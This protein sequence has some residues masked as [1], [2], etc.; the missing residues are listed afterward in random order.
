RASTTGAS[1][2]GSSRS[3]HATA[4]APDSAIWRSGTTTPTAPYR[5]T[6][7]CSPRCAPERGSAP[8]T[9]TVPKR[10]PSP[11][12]SG[13]PSQAAS[14]RAS[15]HPG[16]GRAA[17]AHTSRSWRSTL[18]SAH[19]AT[20]TTPGQRPTTPAPGTT[21][22]RSASK[23]TGSTSHAA[24]AGGP[25]ARPARHRPGDGQGRALLRT[26]DGNGTGRASRL[27]IRTTVVAGGDDAN[28]LRDQ[29][30]AVVARGSV[31]HE[32]VTPD[33]TGRRSP[34]AGQ[35]APTSWTR[36]V[37]ADS[38]AISCRSPLRR[39]FTSITPFARP[40]P[41][42]TIVGTPISSASVNLT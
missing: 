38:T 7:H 19:S 16:S 20:Q 12:A 33:Q 5:N 13:P 18:R 24:A 40:R 15:A 9:A 14:L 3:V 11:G 41:T 8:V 2:R 32:R 28:R 31:D 36:W 29:D 30:G 42:T 39:S 34:D 10:R 17:V 25:A 1:G 22:A 21:A 35:R 6:A 23:S 4:W 27:R 26:D 37:T